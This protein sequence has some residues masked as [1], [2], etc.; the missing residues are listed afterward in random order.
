[1][2]GPI[3]ISPN[4]LAFQ[5]S[6]SQNA[7][8]YSNLDNVLTVE[9]ATAGSKC[10]IAGVEMPT[11]NDQ[12]A[13]KQYVDESAAGILPDGSVTNVKLFTGPTVTA[14]KCDTNEIVVTTAVAQSKSGRLNITDTTDSTASS[15]GCL[16]LSGGIGIAKNLNCAGTVTALQHVTT[17]D[18]R[19]KEDIREIESPGKILRQVKSYSYHIKGDESKLQKY[20]VMA[21]DLLGKEGLTSSVLAGTAPGYYAVD[22]TNF[23][24]LL[25][26]AVNELQ[27]KVEMLEKKLN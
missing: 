18:R 11:A 5:T 25:I 16:V 20:G 9:G 27:E 4:S 6:G 2:N 13:T 23:V 12:A 14:N 8:L 26:G 19:L 3:S 7:K 15:D 24:G 10:K 17:S 1:M 21:Q 22:Y